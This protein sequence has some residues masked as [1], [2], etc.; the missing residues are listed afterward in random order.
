MCGFEERMQAGLFSNKKEPGL[1]ARQT[2]DGMARKW[3]LKQ[4]ENYP[5]KNIYYRA[6]DRV[7]PAGLC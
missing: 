7:R 5:E 6:L 3:P 2:E 1:L 4:S